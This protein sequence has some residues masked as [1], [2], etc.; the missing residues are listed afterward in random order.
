MDFRS[1]HSFID[2]TL[3]PRIDATTT[4]LATPQSVKVENG[5]VMPCQLEVENLTWWI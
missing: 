1:S 2:S 5:A 3:L 4:P